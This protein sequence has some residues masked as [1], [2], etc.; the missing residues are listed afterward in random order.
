MQAQKKQY[1]QEKNEITA[2]QDEILTIAQ[3]FDAFRDDEDF[4]TGYLQ[5]M[6]QE[7]SELPSKLVVIVQERNS[8]ALRNLIHKIT[9]TLK[10]LP[11]EKLT[12]L[13]F[14]LKNSLHNHPV[15]HFSSEPILS[16]I[17]NEC[18]RI[19]DEIKLLEQTFV[20]ELKD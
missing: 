7:F 2:T 15:N 4:I 6:K 9:P 14:H 20:K 5:L 17:D 13:L 11:G 19:I 8:E 18:T 10:R 16:E 3:L 12:G 1:P